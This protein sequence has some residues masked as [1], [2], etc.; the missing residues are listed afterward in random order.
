MKEPVSE[1]DRENAALLA[2]VVE[3]AGSVIVGLRPDHRI[4]AWNRAAE[5]LYQTPRDQAL[6]LDYVGTFIAPEHREAVSADIR[7]VLAGKR[8][9]N[10]EDDSVLPDGSRRT[11]IWNVTR[12]LGATGEPS[13]IVAIGQDITSRKEAD[14]RFRLIFEHAE[15]GLLISDATGVVECNPAALRILGLEHKSQLIGK[16]P[17]VFSPPMQPD[18]SPSDAKSRSIG[19]ETLQKGAHTFDWTHQRPDGTPVPVEVSVRH[20]RLDGRRVSVVSW[21]DQ[22]RRVELERERALL[23]ERLDLAQKMEAVGQLAGGVAHDFNNLLAAIR[24]AV[25][26]AIDELPE[27]STARG[28]LGVALQ[29]AERAAG[30]TRQLLAFSRQQPRQVSVVD[31]GALVRDL[32]PLLRTSLGRNVALRLSVEGEG[33]CVLA[34]RS[35]LEQVV[36]NLVLNARDA[37]PDGGEVAVAIWV[38]E[39]RQQVMLQVADTGTGMDDVTRQRIFEPFFTTKPMGSGTGLGLSVVYGVVT[40][41]GGSVQVDSELG[42]GS[43]MRVALPLVRGSDHVGDDVVESGSAGNRVILLVDDEAAVRSTTRR[44]LERRAWRVIEAS[45][46]EEAFS[47]F[48]AH[49]DRI[50]LLLTDVR[51][52]GLDGASL[53]RRVRTLAPG[54]PAVFVS[55]YDELDPEEVRELADVPLVPKPFSLSQLLGALRQFATD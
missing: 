48:L 30:L 23:Q 34:D 40:H 11:L 33:A 6:G 24:N 43:T 19:A 15:D 17:A 20:A 1:A 9:L 31:L 21:R 26:L 49:R 27:D 16:R 52:P 35:Q 42:K 3:T 55:G 45:N 28:D 41:A 4:F 32:L 51:M 25:Q 8:T 53:V 12:V 39:L 7:E 29:T 36:L 10:F 38:D 46:G 47:L 54:F 44:L 14:E 18:G 2:A 13:G 5:Q 22:S 50:D 37:M